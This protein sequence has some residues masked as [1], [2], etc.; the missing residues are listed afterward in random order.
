VVA[1]KKTV[2]LKRARKAPIGVDLMDPKR[3]RV[4]EVGRAGDDSEGP[5]RVDLIVFD[6]L[7]KRTFLHLFRDAYVRG[8]AGALAVFDLTDPRTLR[9][10]RLWIDA[11]HE[12]VGNIPVVVAGNKADLRDRIAVSNADVLAELGPVAIHYF[13]TSAKTGEGVE[14]AFL[15]LAEFASEGADPTA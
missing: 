3:G 9:N 5:I 11:V 4:E 2:E 10:L 8:A 14:D 1:S 13:T 12:T 7:G 6:I 15:R